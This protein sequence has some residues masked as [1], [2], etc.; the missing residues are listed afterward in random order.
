MMKDG[1]ELVAGFSHPESDIPFCA[2]I[3]TS[4]RDLPGS[5]LVTGVSGYIGGRLVP[6]LLERGYRVRA[7]VRGSAGEV[8][9]RWPGAEIVTA[10]ALDRES[11]EKVLEGVDTAYYLIHSMLLGPGEV[12]GADAQA[13]SN[14][15]TVAGE[16][17]VRR[18]I[19]LGGLG[20]VRSDLSRHLRSRMEVARMLQSGPAPVTILRAAIIIGSGSASYEMLSNLVARFPLIFTPREVRSLCQ[21]ISIRDVVK[22]LVG[23]LESEETAGGSFDIGGDEVMSY[24]EMMEAVARILDRKRLFVTMPLVSLRVFGYVAGLLTPVP[25]PI[26]MSLMEGLKNDVV[27]GDSAIRSIIPFEPLPYRT[28]LVRAM[29]REEQDRVHTRWSD[30]YPPARELA[31]RLS[32]VRDRPMYTASRSIGTGKAAAALFESI[33]R[34][35][36]REGWFHGNWMWRLRGEFDRVIM[37]VGSRRGRKSSGGLQAG[38]VVDFWRVE[39][40]IPSKLLLLRAEMKLPGKAWLEFFIDDHGDRRELSLT[41]R[42]L[43]TTLFG[44]AYWYVFLPFHRFIFSGLLRQIEE[45]SAIPAGGISRNAK[46]IS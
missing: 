4:P 19:Y 40:I 34:I 1:S 44:R 3:P 2:D 28:A 26:T 14:F 27:C 24:R 25:A 33:C 16:R 5:V 7:M 21:P 32:E 38:D 43:T 30:A 8:S 46:E 39:D 9:R 37:G 11:L 41:A 36:G 29:S 17:G 10:D 35:G 22:Y 45:R 15:A 23:S 6:E 20:D 31:I 13:A 42:Y 18:I 12:A